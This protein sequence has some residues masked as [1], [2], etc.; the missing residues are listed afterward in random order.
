MYSIT[1]GA[2]MRVLMWIT[3]PLEDAGINSNRG[4]VAKYENASHESIFNLPYII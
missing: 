2:M 3:P 4:T 1:N